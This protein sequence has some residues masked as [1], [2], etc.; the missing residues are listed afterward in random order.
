MYRV[1]H[2]LFTQLAVFTEVQASH[3][4]CFFF[5]LSA[6][7]LDHIAVFN[8]LT[9]RVTRRCMERETERGREGV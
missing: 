5:L 3:S 7:L 6:T 1:P 8:G 9:L 4:F 2:G